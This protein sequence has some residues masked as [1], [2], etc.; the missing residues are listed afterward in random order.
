MAKDSAHAQA[1]DA[2]PA[3]P[4]SRPLRYLWQVPLFL[5]GLAALVAV[6]LARS[7]W[8]VSPARDLDRQL[9]AVRAAL[10]KLPGPDVVAA[11]EAALAR[12]EELDQRTGE[13][14]FLLGSIYLRAQPPTDENLAKA[15]QHLEE[16]EKLSVP[17][18][19]ADRLTYRLGVVW[20]RSGVDPGK[21]LDYLKRAEKAMDDAGEGYG[22][23]TQ[24]CL[25]LPTP[26]LEAA[27][28]W[29]E[30]HLQ[31]PT[32]NDALLAPPRL[33]RGELYLRLKQASDARKVLKR[34][35]DSAPPALQARARF[36]LAQSY[37]EEGAWGEAA[38]LWEQVLADPRE[39][40]R[41][42][43]QVLYK[44]GVCRFRLDQTAEAERAWEAVLPH[45][46]EEAQA[47]ALRLAPLRLDGNA[48]A[49]ALELYDRAL[50]GVN[51]PGEYGNAYVGLDEARQVLEAGCKTLRDAN[52]W[53]GAHR[54]AQ[55]YGRL[56]EGY[57]VQA[58]LGDLAEAWGRALFAEA[59]AGGE[60]DQQKSEAARARCREAAAAFAAVAEVRA[61]QPDHADWLFRSGG[62]FLLAQ[63]Y[64]RA[65]AILER[66]VKLLAP[67]E[68]LG[69]AWLSLAAAYR[70]LHNE[71][72]ADAALA[73]C[74]EY[75]GPA[76]FRARLQLA[77]LDET[78]GS[79][80][81]AEKALRQ[82]LDLT[83]T[84]HDADAQE[85]TVYALGGLL[86][87]RGK[88]LQA[89]EYLRKALTQY[90]GNSEALSA[91]VQLADA[92]RHL[93]DEEALNLGGGNLAPD[94]R[95]HYLR[96]KKQWLE[97]AI[98]Q[99][100][101][102]IE[103]LGARAAVA[104][105]TTAEADLLTDTRFRLASAHFDLDNFEESARLYE[106]L[107][108]QCKGRYEELLAYRQLIRCYRLQ[109]SIDKQSAILVRAQI[110]LT[111]LRPEV[112]K[113]RPEAESR[114][115]WQR[116][117]DTTRDQLHSLNR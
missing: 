102:I 95:D 101:Q 40:P 50:R 31:L 38:P 55:L 73:K 10:G 17:E 116:W 99:Y 35:G 98:L 94:A 29:N 68:R 18:S 105:L 67:P 103:A 33:L 23:L 113:G 27:L 65:A 1:S 92:C 89:E 3:E 106:E 117:I 58:L 22:L 114:Q 11:A 28:S 63:D 108:E 7:W 9:E 16:A 112:F 21:V 69:E 61:N 57:V 64:A 62:A 13:A 91:R 88:Y 84:A 53:P 83:A 4:P 2:A 90:P 34:I 66:F 77:L 44:L 12:S 14:H 52:D 20:A 48:R 37:Y 25:R 47:A 109:G 54:L 96:Q 19:D 76:V 42:A 41:E 74:A 36:L 43:G 75:S 56:T 60:R 51:R 81:Q 71:A 26:D 78:K 86:H 87:R 45:G 59:R 107:A 30:K 32:A 100:R 82:T 111:D 79:L 97:R 70:G 46:G 80:D 115:G 39:P 93:A 104:P 15:R 24:L 72:A 5:L 8:H 49:T 6:P 110:A 85:R